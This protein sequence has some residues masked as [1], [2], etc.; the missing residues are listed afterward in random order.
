MAFFSCS[1]RDS[2]CRRGLQPGDGLPG[3]R[4]L[5]RKVHDPLAAVKDPLPWSAVE[6]AHDSHVV[7][8]RIGLAAAPLL[9]DWGLSDIK[10][11]CSLIRNLGEGTYGKVYIGKY[12]GEAECVAVKISR[13]HHLHKVIAAT[14]IALLTRMRGHENV[15]HLRFFLF[16]ILLRTG[17]EASGH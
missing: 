2:P 5:K 10:R 1:Q 11:R 17:H 15:I 8:F 13:A 7:A 3:R 14:E 16:A 4:R 12:I 6:L 9:M